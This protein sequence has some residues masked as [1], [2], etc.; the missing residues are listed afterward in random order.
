[1]SLTD[2]SLGWVKAKPCGAERRVTSSPSAVGRA[3]TRRKCDLVVLTS[4][5]TLLSCHGDTNANDRW[6]KEDLEVPEKARRRQHED[7]SNSVHEWLHPMSKR[8]S[9]LLRRHGKPRGF[10]HV[11]SVRES[12]K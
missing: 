1:M 8:R 6:G 9:I 5:K 7:A 11:Y 3:A 2:D 12:S 4:N 10:L